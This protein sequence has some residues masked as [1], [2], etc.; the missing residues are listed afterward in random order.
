LHGQRRLDVLRFGHS[1]KGPLVE[2]I[3][4]S[5]PPVAPTIA[6]VRAVVT[7]L[8]E[9]ASAVALPGAQIARMVPAVELGRC[10]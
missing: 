4:P 2:D 6:D 1:A 9:H 8:E 3:K 10:R 7:T 5:T